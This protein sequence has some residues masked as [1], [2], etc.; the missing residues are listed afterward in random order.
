MPHLNDAERETAFY[1]AVAVFALIAA[2]VIGS[3]TEGRIGMVHFLVWVAC[4][5]GGAFA[6]RRYLY[7]PKKP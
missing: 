2:Y 4:V 7:P 3:N 5:V 6:L 1:A